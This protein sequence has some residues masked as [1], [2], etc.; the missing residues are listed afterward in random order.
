MAI[1]VE[2]AKVCFMQF[3]ATWLSQQWFL[4]AEMNAKAHLEIQLANERQEKL[5]MLYEAKTK[6]LEQ[7]LEEKAQLFATI[8]ETEPLTAL[9]PVA[10]PG[11]ICGPPVVTVP[12]ITPG[13]HSVMN[14]SSPPVHIQS[15]LQ[16]M[17]LLSTPL[18]R[19]LVQP[20]SM[21]A[22][23]TFVPPPAPAHVIPPPGV[24]MSAKSFGTSVVPALP[25]VVK[26]VPSICLLYTSP[27]P[28][29]RTRSRM[30]SSA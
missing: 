28:R 9:P 21:P 6:I 23:S 18:Q 22:C 10:D 15:A 8:S 25:P 2:I 24:G 20:P 17:P 27:S 13:K 5:K 4:A 16:G 19:T 3:P 30:P 1:M 12:K 29:D 7:K 14:T 26:A 11:M